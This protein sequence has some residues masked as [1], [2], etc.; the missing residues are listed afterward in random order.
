VGWYADALKDGKYLDI[1]EDEHARA[2][3][4]SAA[5]TAVTRGGGRDLFL[6]SGGVHL[7]SC[8]RFLQEACGHDVNHTILTPAEVIALL[9]QC[10]WPDP[11]T[12]QKHALPAYWSIRLLLDACAAN[13]Y[14]LEVNL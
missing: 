3:F 2:T 1:E 7:S 6:D 11:D 13:G 4:A 8:R 5:E 14:G 10:N 9:K 12:V